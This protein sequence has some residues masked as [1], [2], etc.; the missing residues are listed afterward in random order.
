MIGEVFQSLESSK[1]HIGRLRSLGN[2]VLRWFSDQIPSFDN[3]MSKKQRTEGVAK[4]ARLSFM[5][6]VFLLCVVLPLWNVVSRTHRVF[7]AV[8]YVKRGMFKSQSWVHKSSLYHNQ[9]FHQCL[10]WSVVTGVASFYGVHHD[11]LQVTKRMG[12]IAVALMPPL[13]FLTLRPS[14]LPETLYLS[15]IPIHKWISRVVVVEALLH[16]VL[17]AWYM[18]RNHVFLVKMKKM[19]NLYGLVAMVLFVVIAVTSLQRFRRSNFK[20]FYSVHYLSTWLSV[21]LIHLHARPGTPY[22][23]LM[24]CLILASQILYRVYRTRT[25]TITA[26]NISKSLTLIEFPLKDLASKPILPSG[27]I[28]LSICER[29]WLKRLIFYCVP[30]QHPYTIASLPTDETVKLIV[31]NGRFPLITNKQYLV[32]GAF[33]PR[34]TFME[35][36]KKPGTSH[37][38][39]LRTNPFHLSSGTLL[40]S[41]LSFEISARRVLM[42]VGGSAISFAL[43]LLRILN[44]NGV[45]VKLL[46]VVRDFRDL[47]VLHHF[48]NNFDGLEI[49]ISGTFE[50]EQDIQIDYIDSYGNVDSTTSLHPPC[51]RRP[52]EREGD[53]SVKA[54]TAIGEASP[55]NGNLTSAGTTS[56]H[57]SYGTITDTSSV[58]EMGCVGDVDPNDEIDF[59]NTFS[60]RNVRSRSVEEVNVK[61]PNP[62]I[63]GDVFRKPSV[64][65]P[66][67][68]DESASSQSEHSQEE[69]QEADDSDM[70]LRIPSGVKTVF[71]RPTLGGA[72][73][74]WCLQRECDAETA[75]DLYCRSRNGYGADADDLS[76]VFVIAAGPPSLIESTRRFATDAGLHFHAESFAV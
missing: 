72:E 40:L 25:T 23:T 28:R 44:F 48:K 4:Y 65:E 34:L 42:C 71:G 13:L 64:I 9:S 33:E 8:Q 16:S 24:N 54:T 7:R 35:K 36:A 75:T 19:A 52:I 15:L 17:Y 21:V 45:T 3:E 6:T 5:V 51:F 27:H 10:L 56:R 63:N 50:S 69:H 62:L 39:F 46:W 12:R 58:T 20:L 43:P 59:T 37:S 14:P 1:S 67:P 47:K 11:L 31:R 55:L 68:S 30:L 57:K 38:H 73:Y 49:Y 26:I 60:A 41:R 22:Y 66:P 32:T 53:V 70:K 29:N 18:A 2:E 61:K 74:A 76:E